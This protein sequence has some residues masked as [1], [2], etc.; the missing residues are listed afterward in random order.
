MKDPNTQILVISPANTDRHTWYDVSTFRH[1]PQKNFV[2]Y[3]KLVHCQ[4]S[5]I[6]LHMCNSLT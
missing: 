5:P 3:A 4:Y 2:H 6:F 1:G